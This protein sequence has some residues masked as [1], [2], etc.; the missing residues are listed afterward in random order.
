[1]SELDLKLFKAVEI[2]DGARVKPLLAA[3]QKMSCDYS[4]ANLYS[5][6]EIY[7]L[8]WNLHR[9]RLMVYSGKDDFLLMPVG[10]AFSVGEM[11]EISDR[12]IR[13]GRSG[14]FVL[15]DAEYVERNES[16][17]N[18]F[19]AEVDRDNA[20]YVY[21]TQA[22]VELKGRKLHKKKNL[23]SQ[24]LRNNPDYVCERMSARHARECFVLAEKWCEVK[25][26]E[27]LGFTHESSALK[28]AMEKFNE[29]ELDG[30]IIRKSGAVIA[31]SI[32][33]RQN[34]NTASV[35]FEKYDG[36][37][38]GSAQAI[39]WETARY[40]SPTYEYINREQDLGIEGLRRA[41][42]SYC[43]AFTVKTYI[44]RR[45]A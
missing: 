18:Y 28:R 34:G 38:K 3:A 23:L 21:A 26:C 12:L 39:N 14:N 8:R 5:W 25:N 36:E 35:H 16:L 9:E 19:T 24:F 10:P 40:L 29:L 2:A 44:L 7:D 27:K 41:K 32:F 17:H 30:L 22:L 33:D 6:G 42:E 31:F 15:V 37:I 20:D 1:M 4:F 43:P 13:Q 45:K 11:V